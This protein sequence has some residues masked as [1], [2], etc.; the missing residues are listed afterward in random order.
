MKIKKIYIFGIIFSLAVIFADF[1]L[2][3][4][5]RFFY[6]FIVI[7]ILIACF[8]FVIS[9]IGVRGKEKEMEEKFLEFSRDLVENVKSG[10]P[11][12]KSIINLRMR[13]YGALSFYVQKLANQI[14]LGI[15]LTEA[16]MIF[17][18]DTGSKVISRAVVLISE[19]ERAGG[20]I[21][22]IL[23]SVSNSVNQT[24]TL[25]KERKSAVFNLIVQG[26]IIF[27]I[28]II[29]MLILE[30]KIIPM[31][32]SGQD[33]SGLSI[34]IESMNPSDFAMPLLIL[35]IV[36]AFFSGLVIGKI[37]EGSLKDGVKHSFILLALTL[38]IKTG[39][40]ALLG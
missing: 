11:I 14:S 31:I 37:S 8:P 13:N 28:F 20:Q 1:F 23:E 35:L 6:F 12:S 18:R 9:V 30:F 7:A 5:T 21:D 36:Q 34:K 15:P 27:M 26:Y 17:A 33:I 39:V 25:K 29:I 24:E 32:P 3:F 16:L 22:S 4:N 19:A 10:T 38:L 40:T 2:F